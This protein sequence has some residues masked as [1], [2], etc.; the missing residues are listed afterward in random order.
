[1]VND[2][3]IRE[4]TK[5]TQRA[6]KRKLDRRNVKSQEDSNGVVRESVVQLTHLRLR[7]RSVCSWV[8]RE[9]NNRRSVRLM[10]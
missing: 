9:M 5:A 1:M 6:I 8:G 2:K 10:Q 4:E 7:G 3:E